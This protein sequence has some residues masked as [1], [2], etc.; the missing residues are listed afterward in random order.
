M[1][2]IFRNVGTKLQ[3]VTLVTAL[4]ALLFGT[5]ATGCSTGNR[6]DQ[7]TGEYVDDHE[8]TSRVRG[9]LRHD[10]EYKF[11]DIRVATFRRVVQLSGFANTQELKNRAGEIAKSVPGV[12]EV[13]NNIT[14]KR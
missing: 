14:V 13:E 3:Q 1:K 2:S 7:S 9:A 12:S 4:V 5:M 10:P 6:Y 8:I 11:P